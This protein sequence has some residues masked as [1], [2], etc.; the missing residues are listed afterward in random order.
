MTSMFLAGISFLAA[1]LLSLACGTFYNLWADH[2]Y[3]QVLKTGST[4]KFTEPV[5]LTYAFVLAVV[6]FSLTAMIHNA[7]E[8]S[9]NSRLHQLGIFKSVG[10]TP[11]QIRSLLLQEA[12]VICTAP[13]LAG[14][15]AG[16]VL[17]YG[18]MQLIIMVTH[19]V[20]RYDVVFRYHWGIGAAACFL[21]MTTILFSAWIPAR[22]ISRMTPLDAIHSGEEAPVMR[23]KR[24]RGISSVFG[25]YGEL[26]RKSLYARRKPLRTST[27]SLM[28]SFLA[29]ISFL[30]LEAISGPSTQRTYFERFRDVW[31]VTFT[32]DEAHLK[33]AQ[34]RDAD[35]LSEIR[36]MDGVEN[37][38]VYQRFMAEAQVSEERFSRE[39]REA[40][41]GILK[42]NVD[43]DGAG[44][45]MFQVPVYVLDD[46]SFQAYQTANGVPEQAQVIGVNQIWDSV[47]SDRINKTYLPI[48]D[49]KEPLE[50][51]LINPEA[52]EM[53]SVT[54][55]LST[56]SNA[57]PEIKEDFI[58]Y[59]LSLV[60]SRD[61]YKTMAECFPGAGTARNYNIKT[62]SDQDSQSVL[63]KIEPL[64]SESSRYTLKS[65]LD[66]E[67]SD[68]SMRNAMKLVI[69]ALAGLLAC[70]GI[71]NVFSSVLGQIY[72][73][74]RE[75]ARYVS[76]GL[77]PGGIKKILLMEALI[78]S[79]QPLILSLL[80]NIPVIGLALHTVNLPVREF[81][82]NAPFLPILCF[83]AAVLCSI[84]IAYG[85]GIRYICH[86]D[87][88]DLLKDETMI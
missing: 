63:E 20:R 23:M 8:V 43:T 76:A 49:T 37:C 86:G 5:V 45:Y 3:R 15:L 56:Y 55:I 19:S 14:V 44:T 46:G 82:H 79:L 26:A 51:S 48:L 57:L 66:Q 28:F 30:N 16:I 35:L 13:V 32:S 12:F 18:F 64:L 29:L 54:V 67:A 85:F 70:I 72:Q 75:F 2:V 40:E 27:I 60:I 6:C 62:A 36:A 83:A 4:P 41:H 52:P 69:G 71:T 50:L 65:R 25:I 31:D 77:S 87:L 58:Q 33:E 53:G 42:G 81:I 21:S 78:I 68:S 1:V 24:F 22:H 61:F 84:G 39:L 34:E 73:R 10:A 88:V 80:I 9:M 11:R 74:K 38:I 47:H 7:F 59:S 17:S